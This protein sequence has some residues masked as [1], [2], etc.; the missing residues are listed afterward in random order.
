MN[1]RILFT[2]IFLVIY[3]ILLLP[4]LLEIPLSMITVAILVAGLL[5]AIVAHQSKHKILTILFL[6]I[7]MSLE[8][9][10]MVEHIGHDE[11]YITLGHGLHAIFDLIFLYVLGSSIKKFYLSLLLILVL[12]FALNFISRSLI[13]ETKPFVMGGILGCIFIHLLFHKN[14]KKPAF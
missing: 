9:P 10:H 3:L 5:F 13:L 7:H 1:M 12:S 8:L 2:K 11:I 6:V 14:I 4:H